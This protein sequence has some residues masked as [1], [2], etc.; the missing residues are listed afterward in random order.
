M[1][2]KQEKK[3]SIGKSRRTQKNAWQERRRWT[4]SS[5]ISCCVILLLL[6]VGVGSTTQW[7]CVV[8]NLLLCVCVRESF[9]NNNF[10]YDKIKT[11]RNCDV[12]KIIIVFFVSLLWTGSRLTTTTTQKSSKQE[13]H[14]DEHAFFPFFCLRMAQ[15]CWVNNCLWDHLGDCFLYLA[16]FELACRGKYSPTGNPEAGVQNIHNQ[17]LSTLVTL[18]LLYLCRGYSSLPRLV[19]LRSKIAC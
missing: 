3:V 9:S 17:T 14:D 12:Q 11:V 1:R 16:S 6:K 13:G 10:F 18:T 5:F 7:S 15:V 19:R 4:K 8:N 2:L